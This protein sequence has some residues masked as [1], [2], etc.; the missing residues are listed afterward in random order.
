MAS[1][2]PAKKF[3]PPKDIRFMVY[4]NTEIMAILNQYNGEIFRALGKPISTES[5]N[6]VLMKLDRM[7]FLIGQ[8][9]QGKS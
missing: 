9:K 8:I 2:P 7:K 3:Q 1:R 6:E 4:T 5:I